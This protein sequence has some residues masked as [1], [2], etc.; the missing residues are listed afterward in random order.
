MRKDSVDRFSL[1]QWM[2]G[3]LTGFRKEGSVGD[4]DT[5]TSSYAPST[6][7]MWNDIPLY[8]QGL[9]QSETRDEGRIQCGHGVCWGIRGDDVALQ[10]SGVSRFTVQLRR[11]RDFTSQ[12]CAEAS[13]S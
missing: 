9:Q 13:A 2:I 3:G 11:A 7:T 10:L 6:S 8:G 5:G 12:E 4:Q 1:L